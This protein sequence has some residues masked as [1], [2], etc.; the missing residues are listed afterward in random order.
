MLIKAAHLHGIKSGTIRLAFRSWQKPAVKA[1]TLMKTFIGL[2]K[3]VSIVTIK[4][5]QILKKDSK[6]AGFENLEQLL[7]SLNHQAANNIYKIELCYHSEDPR[8]ELRESLLTDLVY[9]SLKDKLAR[10]DQHSKQGLW[11]KKVLLAIK[12]NPQLRAE[13]LAKLT[14][15]EK[16]W[17]KLNIRKLKNLGLTI[18]HEVGYELSP[19]GKALVK[20]L[21]Q[22]K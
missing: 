8:I 6:D 4:E 21:V 17:L 11:T 3:V 13:D 7:K 5:T 2:V 16:Q 19:L 22:K 14:D 10:L 12:A 20:R 9:A 15:F 18:S 1:G